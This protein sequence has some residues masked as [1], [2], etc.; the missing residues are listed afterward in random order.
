MRILLV[1]DDRHL[2]RRLTENLAAAGFAVDQAGDGELGCYMGNTNEYDAVVLDLGLPGLPGL[3]VLERWRSTGRTMPVLV[4][5]ARGTWSERVAGLNAGA[6]DYVA[7]PAQAAEI[8]ARLRALIRRSFGRPAPVL[9]FGGL[10]LDPATGSVRVGTQDVPLTAHE[11]KV[12]SYLMHRTG[13]IVSQ[14]EL[15]DH[16]YGMDDARDP[17]TIEVYVG[18]LRKKVGRD[19]IRTVR[20]L[21]YRIG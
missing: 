10:T 14:A 4:L 5:S 1:E 16:I 20:G 18:R 12:L 7:K 6:D 17:N 19:V 21:G 3:Q 9:S 13:R 8:V 15:L 11:L 2:S